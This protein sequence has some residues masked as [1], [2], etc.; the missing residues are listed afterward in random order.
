MERNRPH[1]QLAHAQLIRF[2]QDELAIAPDAI[3]LAQR[4][5]ERTLGPLPMTLW[6]YGLLSLEQLERTWEWLERQG[7]P[8]MPL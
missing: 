2:L 5:C 4:V 7:Q 6:Q 1:S 3:A 8:L